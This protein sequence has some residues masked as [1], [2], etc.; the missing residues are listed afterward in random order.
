MSVQVTGVQPHSPAAR[1]GIR[2]GE[3]VVEIDG[4]E[5]EDFLDYRFFMAAGKVNVLVR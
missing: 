5:I 2:P 1:A 4:N 3:S